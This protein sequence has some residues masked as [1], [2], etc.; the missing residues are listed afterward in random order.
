MHWFG[1]LLS[2]APLWLSVSGAD[3]AAIVDEVPTS[4]DIAGEF[5]Y[6][7]DY[8]APEVI[9]QAGGFKPQGTDW[10]LDE[11]AFSIDHH[12]RA[13]PQGCELD[14]GGDGSSSFRTAYVSA[15][16]ELTTGAGYGG[17]LYEIRATPNILDD[18]WPESYPDGKVF[19][20]GGIPWRQVKRYAR[21]GSGNA[22][23]P[24]DGIDW[25]PN[26]HYEVWLFERLKYETRYRVSTEFPRAL[27]MG[28]VGDEQD[29]L[30]HRPMFLTAQRFVEDEA[31]DL[32][33]SFPLYYGDDRT[34]E[35]SPSDTSKKQFVEDQAFEVRY[36]L[37][38]FISTTD[39]E[40]RDFLPDGREMLRRLLPDGKMDQGGC[41]ALLKPRG[42]DMK[43][44][45][46]EQPSSNSCCKLVASLRE[47]SRRDKQSKRAFGLSFDEVQRLLTGQ[48]DN[49]NCAFL[50]EQIKRHSD[51]DHVP[52]GGNAEEVYIIDEDVN[53]RDC[54]QLRQMILPQPT[55]AIFHA[56]SMWPDEAKKQGGFIPYGT[57]PAFSAY[58]TFGAAARR[59]G[60]F[61]AKGTQGLA[62]V[63]YLVR[64]TSNIL[65]V[66]TSVPIVVA[67]LRW[68]Q[69]IGWVH[70]PH[71]YRAPKDVGTRDVR[72]TTRRFKT[73]LK[74]LS[75]KKTTLFERNPDYDHSLNN[76]TAYGEYVN[77]EGMPIDDVKAFM[78]ATGKDVGWGGDFPLFPPLEPDRIG[79]GAGVPPARQDE[80]VVG[81]IGSFLFGSIG[82]LLAMMTG[83]I[84]L[85]MVPGVV[86][87]EVLGVEPAMAAAINEGRIGLIQLMRTAMGVMM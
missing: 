59:A 29:G 64:A 35:P 52:I 24:I 8:R 75:D 76:S 9:K 22:A 17:W 3:E 60:A 5:V 83:T 47:K 81:R 25:M 32:V 12:Y 15:S 26:P 40:L 23:N 48:F 20:L 82:A 11:D 67:G 34:P 21:I 43:I 51:P 85:M 50:I 69:V 36:E 13:G 84:A 80:G 19:A 10:E 62:G 63:V 6:R 65:V 38:Q 27:S 39:A 71:N 58:H 46:Q 68:K 74:E 66:N 33:G 1:I 28:E 49:L 55:R 44:G 41:A 61:A 2:A 57:S 7:R 42:T 31:S 79:E 77:L 54:E 72:A 56:D 18:Q 30:L 4:H 78:N 86:V 16:R 73:L 87:V 37:E 45:A 53:R 70:I 14:D